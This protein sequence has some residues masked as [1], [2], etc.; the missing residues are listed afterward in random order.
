MDDDKQLEPCTGVALSELTIKEHLQELHRRTTKLEAE[1]NCLK[2]R[3]DAV[4]YMLGIDALP[5]L[6][7][8]EIRELEFR[9]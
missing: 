4:E 3:V 2:K 7:D 1:K 6:C 8:T 9:T 5:S